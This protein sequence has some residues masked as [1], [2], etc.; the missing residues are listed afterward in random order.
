[1]L[2]VEAPAVAV[3]LEIQNYVGSGEADDWHAVDQ[4]LQ[5]VVAVIEAVLV[6]RAL[7]LAAC[8]LLTDHATKERR[9]FF[10][11]ARKV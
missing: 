11:V 1:M 3:A 10:L 4:E 5:L 6:A 7:Q 2:V 9:C 8:P